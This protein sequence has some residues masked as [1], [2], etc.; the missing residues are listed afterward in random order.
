MN[1]F[2]IEGR[3]PGLNEVISSNRSNKFKG[4]KLKRDTQ[5]LI[6][7]YIRKALMDGSLRPV[8]GP[9]EISIH[10]NERTKRRDVDNIQSAQKFILD[11]MVEQGVLPDDSQRFVRQIYHL[12]IP[13]KTDKVE[14]II[15][16]RE[17]GREK[18]EKDLLAQEGSE[19]ERIQAE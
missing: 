10:F 9:V 15:H 6:G 4:A 17:T 16:D 5:D 14:V 18:T 12:I 11:A 3:L 2:T 13:D 1:S 7:F 19:G 8:K